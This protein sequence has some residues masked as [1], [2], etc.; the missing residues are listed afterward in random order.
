LVQ[1]AKR[2][3]LDLEA[4]EIERAPCGLCGAAEADALPRA[5]ARLRLPAPLQ[6][7]RCRR[8]GLMQ[9]NPRLT[10]AAYARR[11]LNEAYFQAYQRGTQRRDGRV[12][13]SRAQLERVERRHPR[14]GRLLEIGCATGEFL[15]EARQAGWQVA[16]VEPSTYMAGE[17]RERHG[18]EV[19]ADFV[20]EHYGPDAFDVVHLNHVLEHV[21][22]PGAMLRGI[23]H[24]LAPSGLLV[25]EVPYEFGGWFYDLYAVLKGA[26]IMPGIHHLSFFT[27]ATLASGLAAAGFAAEVNTSSPKKRAGRSALTRL[28]WTALAYAADAFGR[29]E[30]I[31]AYAVRR[32]VG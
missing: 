10:R 2:A 8:C 26:G 15:A 22:E 23:H 20:P 31:E 28:G 1:A 27:P 4:S 5:T 25:I 6:V 16:G 30:N 11:S 24:I 12:S 29:G 13:T 19:A 7:A 9:V 3:Q 17:A 32:A 14:R 21:P 18:L